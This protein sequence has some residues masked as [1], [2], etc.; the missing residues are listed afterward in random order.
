MIYYGVFFM[1]KK[2]AK[3]IIVL[4]TCICIVSSCGIEKINNKKEKDIDFTV[5]AE[6]EIP[7][8]VNQIIEERKEKEF[9]AAYSDEQYTYIIIGYGKQKYQGYSIMVKK[10]YETKNA[11]FV[12]T[13]FEG[14]KEYTN[15]EIV[16]YPVIVIK[17]EYSDKNIIFDE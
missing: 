13:E 14:P 4:I 9:K 6:N 1:R 16:T 17:M 8:E 7:T 11:V 2:R 12:R 3:L 5:V 15:N 10:L